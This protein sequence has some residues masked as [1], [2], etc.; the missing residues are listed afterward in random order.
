M[1]GSGNHA[2]TMPSAPKSGNI[3]KLK[4]QVVRTKSSNQRE[5]GNSQNQP[6]QQSSINQQPLTGN[7]T[8]K[9]KT[10]V[11]TTK[12]TMGQGHQHNFNMI[13]PS[14]PEMNVNH[15]FSV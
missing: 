10:I 11:H 6:N 15:M 7:G 1:H 3:I 2:P 9:K 14:N 4:Q 5:R 8:N 13:D 12:N